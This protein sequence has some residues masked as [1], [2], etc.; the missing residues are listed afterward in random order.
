MNY[1]NMKKTKQNLRS[2]DI[3]RIWINL[4]FTY[5]EILIGGGG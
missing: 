3:F 2:E 4:E 1:K 5:E